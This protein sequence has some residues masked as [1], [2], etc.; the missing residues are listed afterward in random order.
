MTARDP[1]LSLAYRLSVALA[2]LL[3]VAAVAGLFVP[4]LYR[5][6]SAWTAQSRGVNLVDLV[7]ALPTLVASL[8]LAARG[9][10]RAQV[11]WLG[12]LGYVLY[13]A[14][15]FTFDVAF[16]PLFLVYVGLL[17]LSVFSLIALLTH[18][19]VENLRSRF[20]VDTPIRSVSVYLVIVAALFFLAWMKDIIPAILGNSIPT[21]I[22]QAKIPTNPVYVLD[23][24]F[25]LPLFILSALWLL[26]RR[27]WGYLLAGQLLVLNSLLSLSII[28]SGLFQYANDRSTSLAIVPMFGIITV[29]SV[30]LVIRYVRSLREG[31]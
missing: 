22:V 20:S 26:R 18:L 25:L 15:I 1:G 17:S 28:S 11:V 21:T 12:A 30:V 9:S 13:N 6:T 27:A 4:G 24:G 7:I 23:L 14:V 10:S 2:V 3:F 31:S 19:D 29:V 16:N 8:L 5:D